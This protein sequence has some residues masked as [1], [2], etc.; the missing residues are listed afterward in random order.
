MITFVLM[1]GIFQIFGSSS[2]QDMDCMCFVDSIPSTQE[3]H[4]LCYKWDK[5][6]SEITETD[7]EINSNLAVLKDGVIVETFKGTP[8]ECNNSLL[9]TYNLH[10]QY[11]PQQIQRLVE[12]DV[13]LKILRTCRVLLSFW[14]RSEHRPIVKEALRSDV[15]KK[16]EVISSIDIRKIHNIGKNVSYIDYLK[17]LAFQLGQTLSLIDGV[18]LY[19]KEDISEEYPDLKPF[20]MREGVDSLET[21]EYYKVELMMLLNDYKFINTKEIL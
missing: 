21:L 10:K 1:E 3:S 12:R 16:I 11:H 7:K 19:T 8:E 13:E 18:E 20:L 14:S 2:S 6:I 4:D 17:V 5:Y 15:Y 9:H